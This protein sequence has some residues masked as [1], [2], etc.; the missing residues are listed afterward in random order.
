MQ[1]TSMQ[2]ACIVFDLDSAIVCSLAAR[3]GVQSPYRHA[4]QFA[5]VHAAT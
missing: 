3:W 2:S 5:V 1:V 4:M